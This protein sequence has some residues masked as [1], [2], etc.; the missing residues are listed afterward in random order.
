MNVMDTE[1]GEM[2]SYEKLL[3]NPETRKVWSRAMCKELG[4]LAQG[5]ET[6]EGTNTFFFLTLDQIK[7]IPKG[8]TVTYARIVANYRPQKNDS[9]Y[10]QLKVGGNLLFVPGG[11][12]TT[13]AHLT[14][15]KILWNSV[16]ST[17]NA[18]FA[19]IDI[20][21]MYLQTPMFPYEYMR[22]PITK[23][24]TEFTDAYSLHDKVHNSHV[25]CEIYKG[26]CGLPQTT[27]RQNSKSPAQKTPR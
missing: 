4:R 27:S 5:F 24:P 26:M 18:K 1:S 12:S 11:I 9:L 22:I 16:L 15:S 23:I 25:Y 6:T 19:V 8:K 21:N 3:K 20:H 10:I 17:P 14:T 2:L 7:N 13:T